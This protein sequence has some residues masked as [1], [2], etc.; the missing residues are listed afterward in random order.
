VAADAPVPRALP[1]PYVGLTGAAGADDAVLAGRLAEA[2]AAAAP[3]WRL[4]LG[5]LVGT[6]Q[7]TRG[8]ADPADPALT[9][10][11]A[12]LAAVPG[13]A[14]A[15]HLSP[16]GASLEEDV[17]GLIDRLPMITA[18]QLNCARPEPGAVARIA[19]RHP[20]LQLV[21]QANRRSLDGP[22]PDAVLR[23]ARP[24]LGHAAHLILDL[25]EG[26]GTWLD[27][28]WT[29]ACLAG[30][31]AWRAHGMRAVVAGGLGPGCAPLLA[32]LAARAS[33]PFSVDAEGRVVRC[34]A[35]PRGLDPDAALEYVRDAAGVLGRAWG[36]GAAD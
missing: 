1:T 19:A 12:A 35:G 3:G 15:I 18:V 36:A 25:S 6:G 13:V 30:A 7:E 32:S 33:E 16:P 8:W 17:V 9:D 26:R 2:L 21:V 34:G 31:A 22:G 4:M 14:V 28:A 29:G 20:A 11:C 5:V 23:F 10:A 27:P 24:Y